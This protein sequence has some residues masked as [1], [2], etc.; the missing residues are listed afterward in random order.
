[1][2]GRPSRRG[3]ICRDRASAYTKAVREAAPNGVEVADRWHLLQNLSAAVEKTCHQH[4][5][6]LRKQA[7]HET[8][9]T[10]PGPVSM[11]LPVP[12]LPRAQIIERTRH[13]FE[14]VHRLVEKGWTTSTIARV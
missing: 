4:R 1:M 5:N 9:A 8:E 11:E 3:I 12:E 10:A 6:C 13:R 14:D 7:E 2:A